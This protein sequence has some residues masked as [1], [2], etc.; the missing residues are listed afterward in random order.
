VPAASCD[1]QSYLFGRQCLSCD[2]WVP[3]PLLR[4]RRRRCP[5]YA[6]LWAGDQRRKLFVNLIAYAEQVSS[7]IKNPQV[8]VTAVTAPGVAGGMEWDKYHCRHLGQHE[9]SGDLGC[10]VKRWRSRPWNRTAGKRWRLLHGEAYRRCK[11]EGLTPWVLVRVFELQKRGLL[12]AHPVLAYSIPSERKAADRYVHWLDQ[13]APHYGFG[14]VE[15]KKRVRHPRAAAAYLSSYFINGKGR[16]ASLEESVQSGEMPFSIVHVSQRLTKRSGC[17]MRTL[18]ACRYYWKTCGAGVAFT[19]LADLVREGYPHV[20]VIPR[21]LAESLAR[22]ANP[23][24]FRFVAS[25]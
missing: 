1:S 19:D 3:L 16:K 15:R 11:R 20:C 12:H 24:P 8:L 23:P 14:F 13:L 7:A 25:Q 17:T 4:C 2:R 10:R 6:P 18:R 5:G 21:D 22:R 9:H